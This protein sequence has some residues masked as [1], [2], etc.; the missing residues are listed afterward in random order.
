MV[1]RSAIR[2]GGER[3]GGVG[4]VKK[5]EFP[6]SIRRTVRKLGGKMVGERREGQE[7]REVRFLRVENRKYH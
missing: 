4:R 5:D 7:K 1:V 2:V 6:T 3:R